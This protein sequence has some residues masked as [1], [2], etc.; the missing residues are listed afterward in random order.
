MSLLHSLSLSS[1]LF[2]QHS[3][4]TGGE[5]TLTLW[6]PAM[7]TGKAFPPASAEEALALL[8]FFYYFLQWTHYEHFSRQR[9]RDHKAD[10]VLKKEMKN[11]GADHLDSDRCSS[12]IELSWFSRESEVVAR[13]RWENNQ[14]LHFSGRAGLGHKINKLSKM[15]FS[16]AF[17]SPCFHKLIWQ[18]NRKVFGSQ[19]NSGTFKI[20]AVFQTLLSG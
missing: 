5:N 4:S 10:I 16:K 9:R 17:P 3:M 7:A 14:K 2:S 18:G 1:C 15:G 11:S 8:L 13:G 6:R 12:R 19:Y 20:P